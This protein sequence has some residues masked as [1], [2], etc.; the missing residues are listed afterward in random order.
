MELEVLKG[1]KFCTKVQMLWGLP[2]IFAPL[3]VNVNKIFYEAET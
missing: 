2:L 1:L 3:Y